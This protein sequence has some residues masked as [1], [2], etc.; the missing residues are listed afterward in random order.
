MSKQGSRIYIL[1]GYARSGKDT[2]GVYLVEKYGVKRWAFADK[3][4]EAAKR[5]TVMIPTSPLTGA[6]VEVLRAAGV[7]AEH[8]PGTENWHVPFWDGRDETKRHPCVQF[9]KVMRDVVDPAIWVRAVLE[10][11]KFWTDV[12]NTGV[13]ITDC[14]YL[15]EW[16]MVAEKAEQQYAQVEM[17]W[18]EREG[19]V[20]Q[21]EEAATTIH[22]KPLAVTVVNNGTIQE[23]GLRIDQ[24]LG[25]GQ[26]RART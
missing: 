16:R 9:G 2:A 18:L 17:I 25:R 10:D 24:A 12:R 1:A 5:L 6:V 26:L 8:E 4:K 22:L 13:V 15:N 20:P 7:D 14:R 11:E 3:L 21:G 23:L 19:T